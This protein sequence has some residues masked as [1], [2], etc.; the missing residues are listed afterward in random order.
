M[1]SRLY[2]WCRLPLTKKYAAVFL[3]GSNLSNVYNPSNLRKGI[4]VKG[5]IDAELNALEATP[6][7]KLVKAPIIPDGKRV[8]ELEFFELIMHNETLPL[9]VRMRAAEARAQYTYPK[10]AAVATTA[11][12]NNSFSA[13]LDRAILRS[14]AARELP[15][16]VTIEAEPTKNG[17]PVEH[18]ASEL[19]KPMSRLRRF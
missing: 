5:S 15:A 6:I 18:P 9:N 11:L 19:K 8:T 14:Q 12:D 10:I 4:K 2:A 1:A 13:M 3:R 17:V 16:P 7:K